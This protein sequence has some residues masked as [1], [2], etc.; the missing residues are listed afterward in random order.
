MHKQK[1]DKEKVNNKLKGKMI[2]AFEEVWKIHK[3]RNITLRTAA[4]IL[5]LQRL[6]RSFKN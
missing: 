1:W 3:K 4:Y 2:E 6:S 5:A